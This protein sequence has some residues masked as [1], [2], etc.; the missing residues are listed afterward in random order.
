M[1]SKP[2]PLTELNQ[3]PQRAE[4]LIPF[5]AGHALPPAAIAHAA[6]AAL[7]HAVAAP[8]MGLHSLAPHMAPAPAFRGALPGPMKFG[9]KGY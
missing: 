5:G 6:T 3:F 9:P 8:A 4:R 1:I 2:P 7:P